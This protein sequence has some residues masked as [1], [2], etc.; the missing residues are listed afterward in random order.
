MKK[1]KIKKKNKDNFEGDIK[2]SW[3][4]CPLRLQSAT[5]KACFNS[6]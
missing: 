3:D 2:I 5:L 4:S 1:K 6:L